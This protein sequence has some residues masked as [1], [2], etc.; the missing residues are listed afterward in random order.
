MHRE[1]PE[2]IEIQSEACL[3]EDDV[4]RFEDLYERSSV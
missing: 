4:V 3:E 2:M 1:P